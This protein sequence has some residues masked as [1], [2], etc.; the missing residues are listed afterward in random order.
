MRPVN[1]LREQ[2]DMSTRGHGVK[3][4]NRSRRQVT[5][6]TVLESMDLANH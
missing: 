3:Q 5:D 6:S 1:R 2:G 4:E